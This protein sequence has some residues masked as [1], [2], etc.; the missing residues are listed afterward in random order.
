MKEVVRALAAVVAVVFVTGSANAEEKKWEE[1]DTSKLS[2]PTKIDNKWYPL[3]PGT[4]LVWD[5][6][7][8]DEKG[9]EEGHSIVFIVTDLT[10]EIGGVETVVIWDRDFADGELEETEIAFFAQD[11]DG[12]VWLMGEY[13]EEYEDGELAMAPAWIHGIAGA[14]GG[15]LVPGNP[16]VGDPMFIQGWDPG[17]GFTDRGKVDQM[18]VT[19]EVDVGK[20]ED[21]LVIDEWTLE[22]PNEH[23]LKYYGPGVGVVRIG[24]R[25]TG[26]KEFMELIRHEKLDAAD[27]AKARNEALKLD[28]RARQY[29]KD[30][31]ANTSPMKLDGKVVK[32]G[33]KMAMPSD[34]GEKEAE[35]GTEE[36]GLS[37]RG[38][39]QSIEKVEASIGQCMREQG[40]Q[41]VSPDYRTVRRGMIADK[42]LPG[43]TERE[44]IAKYG[45]GLSTL[46]TGVPPQLAQGYSPAKIGLGR[47]NV[48]IYKSLSPADQVAYNRALLG[49]DSSATFAVSLEQENFART[50]GCTRAAV[51]EVFSPD[52]LKAS[53]YNPKDAMINEDPRMKAALRE[54]ATAIRKAGFDYDHPDD[55]ETDVQQ[56]LEAIVGTPPVPLDSM[57][58]DTL[59]ALKELQDYERR[60]AVETLNLEE[61]YF[62]P[63]EDRIEKE[64]FARHVK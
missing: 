52:Q 43:M 13:P 59:A 17:V 30:V 47:R 25:G 22:A 41:Y 29:A 10:K 57:S 7:T 20:F 31:Y 51:E 16:K 42:T 45:F 56:R 6:Y 8:T 38:L 37:K 19:T 46:Y 58:P 32:A 15:I 44:F 50:G 49:E 62:E 35:V 63:V 3:T 24:S 53:Y 61:K 60:V 26:E 1:L 23:A 28:E 12:N 2:N 39:V 55:V 14:R 5:G 54:Y 40:F 64:M 4:R 18:G 11:D 34:E 9:E 36:F 48:A 21:V 27:L 33:E